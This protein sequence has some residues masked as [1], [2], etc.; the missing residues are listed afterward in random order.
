MTV[1]DVTGG[2]LGGF[3]QATVTL[4]KSSSLFAEKRVWQ[5]GGPEIRMN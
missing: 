5:E 1:V 4:V 3:C 2:V